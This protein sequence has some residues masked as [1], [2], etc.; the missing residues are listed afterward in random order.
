MV[1]ISKSFFVRSVVCVIEK[2]REILC[3]CARA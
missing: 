2:E 1:G 3:V